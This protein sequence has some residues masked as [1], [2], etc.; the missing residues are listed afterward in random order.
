MNW[1]NGIQQAINYIEEHLCEDLE[2]QVIAKK[3]YSSSFHF[4]RIFSLLCGMTLGEYIRSRRL[5]LAGRELATHPCKVI[6]IAL[7]YG[8]DSPESFSRAFTKFH[9]I[10]PSLAKS[11]PQNLKYFSR[12]S[13]QLTMKGGSVMDY[14]IE[15]KE[16]FY[17]MEKVKRFSTQNEEQWKTIPMFWKE[18]KED[19]TM[20]SLSK[21]SNDKTHQHPLLGVCYKEDEHQEI[22]YAIA[23][24]CANPTPIDGYRIREVNASTWAIFQAKGRVPDAIQETWKRIYTEFFPASEYQPTNEI[25]MEVY[26]NGDVSQPDYTCE[27]WIAV[28]KAYE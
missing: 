11:C 4:Q 5:S 20:D 27:I 28:E 19:G 26:P 7:K 18:C 17:M 22:E 3:A 16:A 13:V 21:L 1:T 10:S 2:Y 9:G 15:K 25:D 8:Y 14:R 12:L 23:V 6:D 24:T